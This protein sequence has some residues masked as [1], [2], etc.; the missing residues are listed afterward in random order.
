MVFYAYEG[1]IARHDTI[2]FQ[3]ALTV[4]VAMFRRVVLETNLENTKEMVCNPEFI[5]GK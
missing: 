5:C 3:E 4:K 2:W 1:R